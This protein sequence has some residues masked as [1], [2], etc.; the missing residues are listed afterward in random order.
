MSHNYAGLSYGNIASMSHKAVV[1]NPR[2]AALQGLKKMKHLADLGFCQGVIAPQERPDV[3]TLRRLGWSGSDEHVL[4]QAFQQAPEVFAACSSASSMWTANAATVS[5]SADSQNQKVHFTPANLNNKF[6]RA[7]ESTTT[8]KILKSIFADPKFF[9]HHDPLPNGAAFDDEGAANHTRLCRE[10]GQ[11]G[12][13]IFVYGRFGFDRPAATEPKKFPGR[14]TVESSLAIARQHQLETQNTFFIQQNPE[15]IDLGA[16]HNDVVAVGNQNV[17][18]HHERA[19]VDSAEILKKIMSQYERVCFDNLHVITVPEDAVTIA[20]AV[21][22]YLFN[23]QLLSLGPDQMLL[24]APS[25]CE[26]NSPVKNYIDELV[27]SPNNPIDQVIYFDLRQSMQNGGGPACLR[28][29]VVL[30]NDEFNAIN[31]KN[32]IND[33]TYENLTTWVHKHYRD[34]LTLNDLIDPK[35]LIET[36]TAL[37]ELTQLLNLGPVYPF[38]RYDSSI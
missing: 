32:I 37:D 29:R 28:L 8:K 24:V 38:Q 17:L 23:S 10:Y 34:R 33:T 1:S 31:K 26:Q 2:E 20:Q 15:V 13:Q 35:F 4:T 7:I 36:R 27:A 16:F 5:P 12:L 21:K 11:K 14:Q 6:H 25:E 19:F 9:I 30:T 18:F 3:Y 22:C